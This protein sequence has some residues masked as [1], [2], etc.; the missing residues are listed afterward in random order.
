MISMSRRARQTF[1][2]DLNLAP[3]IDVFVTLI[4]FVLLST[5]FIQFSQLKVFTPG[6]SAPS[7]AIAPQGLQMYAELRPEGL[8]VRIY[9]LKQQLD[10]EE[11]SFE[12]SVQAEG[13]LNNY[14]SKLEPRKT[15][16]KSI[17]F[18]GNSSGRVDD[19]LQLVERFRKFAP[20]LDVV[21]LTEAVQ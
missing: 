6:T 14:F 7:D 5:V 20:R 19:T 1:D 3:F 17:L 13:Q 8:R 15:E 16:I 11:L 4:V 21:L 2:S 12:G 18:K 10:L 9:D